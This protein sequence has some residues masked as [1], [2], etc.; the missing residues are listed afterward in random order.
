MEVLASC[1]DFLISRRNTVNTRWITATGD[2][3]TTVVLVTVVRERE[4]A[5]S[6]LGFFAVDLRCDFTGNH[7]CPSVNDAIRYDTRSSFHLE[8]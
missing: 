3:T 6:P 7:F 1:D 2:V 5:T 8:S 4:E